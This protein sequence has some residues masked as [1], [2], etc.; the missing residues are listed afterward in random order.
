MLNALSVR[1]CAAAAAVLAAIALPPALQA[2]ART[3][4]TPFF[5]SFFAPLPYGK[6]VIEDPTTT[7]PLR[8][9]E[10]LTNAPGLGVRF[11]IKLA[12]SIGFEGQFAGVFAG[13]QATV[14]SAGTTAG[15][16]LSGN[17]VMLSGRFAYHPRRSNFRGILG[18]G[19]QHLGGDAWDPNKLGASVNKS[20]VGG[21]V[22]FGVRANVTPRLPLDLT[23]ESFL[24]SSD[25]ANFGTKQFQADIML[26]VGVPIALGAP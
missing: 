6:D 18:F 20:S 11:E 8:G 13:R 23:V 15:F 14:T 1:R 17:A 3:Q 19:W 21:V 24:H 12:N 16:F 25:P 4:I 2:Q 7:P 22:G 26:S 9:D 10:R 5:T